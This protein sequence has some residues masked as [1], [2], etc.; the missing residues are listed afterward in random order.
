MIQH[1]YEDQE[2][3]TS[4]VDPVWERKND[5]E[6]EATNSPLE[7]R[8]EN[9]LDLSDLAWMRNNDPIIMLE[10]KDLNN[11]LRLTNEERARKM[12]E[13]KADYAVENGSVGRTRLR[14][15][16]C[17]VHLRNSKSQKVYHSLVVTVAL[18]TMKAMRII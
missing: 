16:R 12:M 14:S 8:I 11:V 10:T 17:V 5:D 13:E 9:E 3:V 1:V 4:F 15:D 6:M 18:V 7:T 2:S